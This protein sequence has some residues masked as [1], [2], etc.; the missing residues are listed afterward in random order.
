MFIMKRLLLF[1]AL[2]LAT[3]LPSRAE[4]SGLVRV[5]S[6]NIRYDNPDDV[7]DWNQRRPHMLDQILFLNPD[8]LGLQE[9]LPHMVAQMAER[10]GAYAHYG[11]GRDDGER[12]ES[13]TI[14][15]RR[16]RFDLVASQTY[17]CSATPDVP[18]IGEDAALPRTFTRLVL[19]ERQ[20]G[21]L[22]DVRNAHLDHVGKR[23]RETC[24][25]QIKALPAYPQARLVVM[26]DF[27]SGT[28]SPAYQVLTA[29]TA[30]HLRDARRV[31]PVLFGPEGTFNDF[32]IRLS[33]Q[34][35]DHIFVGPGLSV[36]RFATLA[37]S[38]QGQVI[39][40]HFPLVAD[41]RYDNP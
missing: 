10:L 21:L 40:D 5:M 41:L 6:Y 36:D 35:I 9:A 11:K 38:I 33:G 4:S 14:F 32:D 22:W 25:R 17:W 16:D 24:A 26:G 37:E 15:F 12:G 19:K 18:S 2:S 31:S 34:A 1:L 30:P 27:N 39:S 8:I 20:S 13:T 3:T 29:E 23:A 28:D 7:P